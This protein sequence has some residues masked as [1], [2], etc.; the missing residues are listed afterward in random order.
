[1]PRVIARIVYA[2]AAVA[3]AVA[4]IG[5]R[6]ATRSVAH[7]AV[8]LPGGVPAVI[9][10]PGE[11]ALFGRPERSGEPLPVV[12]LAHGI[13]SNKGIISTL[14]RRLAGAGYAVIT[15]DFRGHG[16]NRAPLA[17]SFSAVGNG[18]FED[19][20]A[21]VL[22][23]RTDPRFD[24][25]RV[26]IAGHSMGGGAVLSYGSREPNVAAVVAISAGWGAEGPYAPRNLLLIW[27]SGESRRLREA[28]RKTGARLA[29]LEQLV[30]DRTYGDAA[31]GTALR[32]AEVEGA[33]HWNILYSAGA[34]Q[35]IVD[36]LRLTVGPGDPAPREV[37]ADPRIAW[38][39]LGQL[40]FFALFFGFVE[41]LAPLLPR[42]PLPE[43]PGPGKRLSLLIAAVLGGVLLLGVSDGLAD[44]GPFGFVP[45]VAA[46][47]LVGFL[48]ISG[49]ALAIALA[50]RGELR[51]S[52]L[53]RAGTYL[54][55]L[56]LWGFGYVLFAGVLLPFVDLWLAPH[57][58]AGALLCAL[59]ALP[60]FGATEW[61]LRG[62]G[63][64]GIWLPIVGKA[65]TLVVIAAAALIGLL[66]FVIL[67]ALGGLALQFAF[68]ELM[69][70][71]VSRSAPN[72]WLAALLQAAWT[73]WTLGALF[74]YD[75]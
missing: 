10:E 54:G 36:W 70:Y 53:G 19:I 73:G 29:G 38:S 23:A 28:A 52:G 21:A 67:L 5:L 2:V 15:F 18:L 3:L 45:I 44:R 47:D 58:L 50:R 7:Y 37:G 60:F 69:A 31:R 39:L 12:V 64:T 24:G 56:L 35:E 11:P 46:R 72:P 32:L 33:G 14:A 9:Y 66:P 40:A 59:L 4:L 17:L 62:P 51:V 41:L 65:L 30:L 13:A 55:S 34:A 1:M 43:V 63:R 8:T 16:Q 74:P 25:E 71:R 75:A 27:G 61:L 68:Y 49:V 22:Y 20:D 48:A 42:V 6:Q 26:A 57:R